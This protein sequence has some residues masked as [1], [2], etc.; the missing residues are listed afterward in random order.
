MVGHHNNGNSQT[1]ASYDG[2]RRAFEHA[3]IFR[4]A[5]IMGVLYEDAMAVEKQR[6][7]VREI[8]SGDFAP[9]ALIRLAS[10]WLP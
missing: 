2:G 6:R 3:H 1:V 5:E 4:S 7:S 10:A 9:Q 8:P